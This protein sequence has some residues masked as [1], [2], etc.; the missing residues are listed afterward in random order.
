[1]AAIAG[2]ILGARYGTAWIESTRITDSE[3]ILKYADALVAFPIELH[4]PQRVPVEDMESWVVAEL[5]YSEL[6]VPFQEHLLQHV[7]DWKAKKTRSTAIAVGEEAQG[8]PP[9]AQESKNEASSSSKDLA[10]IDIGFDVD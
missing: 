3:R 8:S 10:W 6:E 1:V 5:H 4:T 2:S 9:D 7:Q